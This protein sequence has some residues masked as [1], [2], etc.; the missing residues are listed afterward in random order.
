MRIIEQLSDHIRA[1]ICDAT[2]Y[3]REALDL[4]E[5]NKGVADL[6]VRLAS[7][8][9]THMELLH[10]KVTE[11]I[12]DWKKKTGEEPPAHMQARYDILHKIYMGDANKARLM[13]Q[14]YKEAK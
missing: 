1:E 2:D 11:V 5:E 3:A 6:Y 10:N 14:L 8:E 4:K 12:E 9:L 13:I 7:E